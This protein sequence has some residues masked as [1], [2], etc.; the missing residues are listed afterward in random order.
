MIQKLN[1]L[2]ASIRGESSSLENFKK[3]NSNLVDFTKEVFEKNF[4]SKIKNLVADLNLDLG[5][6]VLC[7]SLSGLPIGLIV[8]PISFASPLAAM[9][10]AGI[11]VVSV[12]STLIYAS[13][14][15][16]GKNK[17]VQIC[18]NAK[19]IHKKILLIEGK[20][21]ELILEQSD[22]Q[23][24]NQSFISQQTE[25]LQQSPPKEVEN[26]NKIENNFP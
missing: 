24:Q 19:K 12:I 22:Q 18:E 4:A 15:G 3:L 7:F 8:L 26:Q 11:L 14:V 6:V 10:V 5:G 21:N 1:D 17:I 2:E 9:I 25:Q 13:V 16:N 23:Q 20:Q